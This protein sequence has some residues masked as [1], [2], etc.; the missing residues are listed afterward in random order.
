MSPLNVSASMLHGLPGNADR[1]SETEACS[2]VIPDPIRLLIYRPNMELPGPPSP[3]H[4]P[5]SS[6]FSSSS[7]SPTSSSH[8]LLS[9]SHVLLSSSHVL[10]SRHRRSSKTLPLQ[11]NLSCSIAHLVGVVLNNRTRQHSVYMFVAM[12]RIAKSNSKAARQNTCS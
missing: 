3:R 5:S 8:V 1:T 11:V 2:R 10:L 4:A 6:F 12:S 7:S 9:S